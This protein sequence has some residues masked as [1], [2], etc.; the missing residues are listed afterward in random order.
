MFLIERAV[1]LAAYS[2]ALFLAY[3]FIG[4]S[5]QY[6]AV[7]FIYLLILCLFAYNYKPYVTADL[8]RLREYIEYWIQKSWP[9]V[10][11]YAFQS[12]TPMWVLYSYII[13]RLGDI[14]LLQTFTC[15]WCF[16]NVFYIIAHEIGRQSLR[17]KQRGCIL[18]YIMAVGAFYL[19]TISGIRSM[20]GI[21]IVAFCLYRETIENK[22]INSHI[23]LYLCAALLHTASMVLVVSRVL[24][25]LIQYKGIIYRMLSIVSVL[26]MALVSFRILGSYIVESFEYGLGYLTAS[27]QYTYIWEV[28]IGIIELIEVAYVLINFRQI[29]AKK[30][31]PTT[32]GTIG[33]KSLYRFVLIWLIISTVAIPLS[34]TIF[35]RF[36]MFCTIG[37]I[38]LVAEAFNLESKRKGKKIFTK[39]IFW[40]SLLIFLLSVSRGD[41]CGYKF[42]VLA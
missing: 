30:I 18:L 21:S 38:P 15:L 16:G 20:L 1:S 32:D 24:F 2:F 10:I 23:L 5:K 9:E 7:L 13:T 26:L 17:G 33:N 19:Q 8:Y 14:N 35:R 28:V 37:T 6:K 31:L 40:L 4:K 29:T 12:R 39:N 34:Y 41:L 36:V 42:F 3:I 11:E 25:I 27:T 22:K